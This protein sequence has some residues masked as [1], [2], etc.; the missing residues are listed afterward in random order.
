[1]TIYVGNLNYRVEDQDLSTL[2]SEYGEVT[3]AQVMK[4]KFSGRSKGFGFVEMA[5]DAAAQQAI[6]A[7]NDTDFQQRKMVVNKARPKTESGDR[8]Q[9]S[10][11]RDGGGSRGGRGGNGGGG[12]YN[13]DY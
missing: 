5:D 10:F 3:S 9:R 4:D 6:D 2:F 7:L 13:R 12:G 8:P 1:M 11:N